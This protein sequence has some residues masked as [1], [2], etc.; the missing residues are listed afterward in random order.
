MTGEGAEPSR[1]VS[2][3]VIFK[4]MA[5]MIESRAQIIADG[6]ND[7]GLQERFNNH[8]TVMDKRI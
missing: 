8:R 7:P 1:A 3:E 4:D 6:V 2:I 5:L